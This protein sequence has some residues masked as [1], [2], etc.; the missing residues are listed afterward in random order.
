[1][2]LRGGRIILKM[3]MLF[4]IAFLFQ[5]LIAGLAGIVLGSAAFY[6]QLSGSYFVVAH[7]HYTLVGGLLIGVF[8]AFYYITGTQKSQ[9]A[10]VG[11]SEDC[12]LSSRLRQRYGNTQ[13]HGTPSDIQPSSRARSRA[14][15]QRSSGSLARHRRIA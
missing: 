14:V 1:V 7:F 4:C 2:E 3:P 8:A 11:R 5:F 13:S 15:C 10:L 9:A 6:W 12:N